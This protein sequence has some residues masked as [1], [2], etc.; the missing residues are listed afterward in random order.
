MKGYKKY[1][2]LF[3]AI[4]PFLVLQIGVPAN[5]GVENANQ[6]KIERAMQ[7]APLSISKDATIMDFDGTVLRKGTNN[8]ICMPGTGPGSGHP[9]CNDDVWMNLL[10]AIKQKGDFKTD[11]IGISY[12]LAGDDNVNNEDPYDTKQDA[13]EIWVKEGPH[14]MIIVPDQKMLQGISHDPENGG[15]YVMWGDTPYA[16]LMVP[17]APRS[18]TK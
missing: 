15:P 14:L 10:T 5:A 6:E 2:F 11:R 16:H 3:M 9:M 12:M 17:V 1:I 7:A 18:E 8:W 4:I 13:G